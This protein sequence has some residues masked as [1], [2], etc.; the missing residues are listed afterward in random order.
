MLDAVDHRD[1]ADR[2]FEA[3]RDRAPIPPLIELHPDL[4]AGRRLRDPA[5]QHRA[6]PAA[7]AWSS[8]T[9]SACPRAAMQQMMGVD[10]PDYGHLLADMG[11]RSRRAGRR[12]PLLPAAGR[13]RGRL[14]A[15]RRPARARAA[16][17]RTC[18]PPPRRSRR[19]IELIDSRIVDWRIS[20]RRHDRRQR[21]VGR[22]RARATTRVDPRPTSTSRAIDAVRCTATASSSSSGRSD[23]VLGNPADR[24]RLA[25]PHG[26]D[27]RRPAARRARHPAGLVHAGGRPAPGRRVPR[28]RSAG[29]APSTLAADSTE[30]A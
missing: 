11:C 19:R 6:P 24:R 7:A 22:V 30:D 23:A 13:A 28:R 26:G 1:L 10:E 27:V 25:R 12:R 4:D 3:E 5:P 17:R 2:L 29:S 21:V 20:L 18:S 15:R 14:P 8:A 9:R 16:P